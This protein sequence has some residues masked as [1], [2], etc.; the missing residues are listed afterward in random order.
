VLQKNVYKF[1]IVNPQLLTWNNVN[2]GNGQYSWICLP[3]LH[4]QGFEYFIHMLSR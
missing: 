1:G 2:Q 3:F 4:M